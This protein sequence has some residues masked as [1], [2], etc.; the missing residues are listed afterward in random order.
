MTQKQTGFAF[1]G[2]TNGFALPGEKPRPSIDTRFKEWT[3]RNP[4]VVEAFI[5]IAERIVSEGKSQVSARDIFG[6]MRRDVELGVVSD[7]YKINNDFAAPM[8]R[9]AEERSSLLHGKFEFRK[10]TSQK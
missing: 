6:D 8:A 7:D 9:L 3:A 1:D 4:H 2:L 10:R 5:T